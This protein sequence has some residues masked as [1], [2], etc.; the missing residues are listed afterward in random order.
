MGQYALE[1]DPHPW[2]LLLAERA[3]SRD[4]PCKMWSSK[5]L[6]LTDSRARAII[7]YCMLSEIVLGSTILFTT[8]NLKKKTITPS[9]HV[10]YLL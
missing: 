1:N 7:H 4:Y 10:I 8:E 5:T 6:Y 3:L 9:A 2:L